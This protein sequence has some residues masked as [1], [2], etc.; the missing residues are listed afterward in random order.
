MYV[1]C[2]LYSTGLYTVHSTVY[3]SQLTYVLLHGYF[4]CL[5]YRIPG[6]EESCRG[7][8]CQNE[9]TC[10]PGAASSS[11]NY[12]CSCLHPYGGRFCE[13]GP[14]IAMMYQSISPCSHHDCQHGHCQVSLF[15]RR[16]TNAEEKEKIVAAV[17]G[18]QFIKFLAALAFLHED[19]LDE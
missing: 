4:I 5:M 17:C 11:S 19:D 18:T 7:H 6:P 14:A 2:T 9:G 1:H 16:R 12:T 15:H 8:L 3:S 13:E 10:V